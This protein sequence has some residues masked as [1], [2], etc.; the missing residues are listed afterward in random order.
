MSPVY[1][2]LKG[3]KTK[4]IGRENQWWIPISD[5]I[6][7]SMVPDKNSIID[8]ETN[9]VKPGT[10]GAPLITRDGIIGM[11]LSD[12]GSGISKALSINRIKD[13][14]LKWHY[15]WSLEK[16]R[17]SIPV[18][19][20]DPDKEDED[21]FRDH[22][23]EW[24][25]FIIK[26]TGCK[27]LGQDLIFSF[28]VTNNGEDNNFMIHHSKTR[29]FDASGNEFYAYKV[30]IGN[31]VSTR[32]RMA[33]LKL[34]SGIPVK[35]SVRFKGNAIKVNQIKL[36]EVSTSNGRIKFRDIPVSI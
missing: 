10:S 16:R 25:N 3:V 14:F 15:P 32:Y 17:A 5:L 33:H 29:I 11:I 23:V 18:P 12:S 34:V 8:V 26:L 22:Y 28:L 24:E 1:E 4:F 35:A 21:I 27:V 30:Q 31:S 7:N 6:I 9:L 36:L 19:T 13:A 2:S 20:T